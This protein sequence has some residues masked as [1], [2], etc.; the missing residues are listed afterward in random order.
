MLQTQLLSSSRGCVPV[1]AVS[2]LNTPA[3]VEGPEV[4][5]GEIVFFVPEMSKWRL[6]KVLGL[7]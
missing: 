4:P 5:A 1:V 3:M 7:D 2:P 6:L